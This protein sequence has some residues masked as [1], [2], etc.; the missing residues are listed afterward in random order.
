MAWFTPARRKAIYNLG[1]ALGI[2]LL[3]FGVITAD[4]VNAATNAVTSITGMLLTLSN[5]L[6][7]LNVN[8]Q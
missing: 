1:V 5:L 2:A 4:D 3:A 6:A 7:S 8:P